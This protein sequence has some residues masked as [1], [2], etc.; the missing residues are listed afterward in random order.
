MYTWR[1]S[2]LQIGN[3]QM[4]KHL[5]TVTMYRY[6]SCKCKYPNGEKN[7]LFYNCKNVHTYF[8]RSSTKVNVLWLTLRTLQ[9]ILISANEQP[10]SRSDI[11]TSYQTQEYTCSHLLKC[12]KCNISH[13]QRIKPTYLMSED[14]DIIKVI[15]LTTE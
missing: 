2:V 9:N 12:Q 14:T 13:Q 1:N 3:I 5:S 11:W 10:L 8:I 6:T 4:T 15:H 7:P